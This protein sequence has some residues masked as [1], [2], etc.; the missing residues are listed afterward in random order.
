MSRSLAGFTVT[1]AGEEYIIALEEEGG[2]TVEFTATY[3]QLD[4]I[5][6]A[7]DQQLNEDEEDVLAVDDNDAS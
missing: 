2:S 4:L 6:D 7:I 1:K 5:A 3:D